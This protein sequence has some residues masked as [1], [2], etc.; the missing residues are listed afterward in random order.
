MTNLKSL[1]GFSQSYGIYLKE[2]NEILKQIKCLNFTLII[3]KTLSLQNESTPTLSHILKIVEF[4]L[5]RACSFS[6]TLHFL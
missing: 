5:P 2:R 1:K 3:Q 6:K 4:S